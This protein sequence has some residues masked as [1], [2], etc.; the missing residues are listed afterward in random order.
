MSAQAKYELT[1]AF[2]F[3]AS[4][5]YEGDRCGG[6]P[7]TAAGYT[8]TGVCAQPVPSFAVYDLFAAYR[9]SRRIDMRINVLNVAN[10]DYFT[11]V[12]RSGSFMYKGDAR[13]VRVTLNYEI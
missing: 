3:G 9:F 11:A 13:A 12:Y 1:D 8:T 2:S 4:A 7:D 5:R 10:K 6:Q